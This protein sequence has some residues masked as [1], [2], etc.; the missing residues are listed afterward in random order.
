MDAAC[1]DERATAALF[2][3]RLGWTT[4]AR[5]HQHIVEHPRFAADEELG[6]HLPRLLDAGRRG[7]VGVSGGGDESGHTGRIETL[8]LGVWQE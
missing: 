5:A 8:F 1:K 2:R 3:L 7:R 4:G 6:A